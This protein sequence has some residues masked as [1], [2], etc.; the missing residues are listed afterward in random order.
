MVLPGPAVF[1]RGVVVNVGGVVPAQWAAADVVAIDERVLA[2]P[3]GTVER[4]HLAWARRQPVVLELQVDPAHFRHPQS[5]DA[6]PWTLAADAEPWYDRLHFLTWANTYDARAGE[7]VW[8]WGVKA[9]RVDEAAA[10]TPA[11]PADVTLGDGRAI[12]VDGGP[13]QPWAPATWA[14]SLSSTA[15]PSTAAASCR[16][17]SRSIRAPTWPPISSPQ[18][19]TGPGRRG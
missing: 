7:P 5:I 12:W 6:E 18:W 13:R 17:P 1:G 16:L 8:W 10:A 19:P 4:L 2:D 14:D 3:A 11:G 9:A 15:S